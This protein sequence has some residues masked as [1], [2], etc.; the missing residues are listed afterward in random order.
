M[1]D[2]WIVDSEL[3]EALHE[4][5]IKMAQAIAESLATS[6][7]EE[8]AKEGPPARRDA[9]PKAH[10]CV[11]AEF[12]VEDIL[13]PNLAQ[14]I[15]VP[16]KRYPAWIRFSNG[17]ANPHRPD[18]KGDARAMAIKVFDV[19]GEKILEEDR[20]APTQDFIMINHPVFLTD[21]PSRYLKLVERSHSTNPLVK[22]WALEALGPKGALTALEVQS[23][24]I[25]NPLAVRY[26]STVP[27]RLGDPPYKQAIKF[28]AMPVG[29]MA[30]ELPDDSDP[31]CLREVMIDQLQASEARFDFLVQPHTSNKMSVEDT[32]TEWTEAEA[33]FHK[34]ATI[35]IPKQV[36][37]TAERDAL[38]ENLSFNPWHALPQHRPLGS[39]NRIR[40]VVYK[41]ISTLRRELNHVSL[42]EPTAWAE[43]GERISADVDGN[44]GAFAVRS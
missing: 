22:L 33:P 34:V 28:S 23:S 42:N 25:S 15:F 21:H 1:T 6:V 31:N 11:S 44:A 14:G 18:S 35:T 20:H 41:T 3:G 38:A 17:D 13:S 32:Q 7:R 40:R 36:F 4:N 12:R 24:K 39:V 26:W 30:T 10:G 5:E 16:G 19:L 43:P 27:Y 29:A 37:A 8:Y 2:E 9:H